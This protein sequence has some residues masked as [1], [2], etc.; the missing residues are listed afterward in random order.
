MKLK[1]Y[2]LL[3]IAGHALIF[4]SC[5]KENSDVFMPDNRHGMDT[6]WVSFI[7]PAM[8]VSML[9]GDL[10]IP[11]YK[12]SIDIAGNTAAELITSS[13]LKFL[14]PANCLTDYSHAPIKGKVD[15]QS[16]LIQ[17]KG[18]MIRLNKPSKVNDYVIASEGMLLISLKKN[19]DNIQLAPQTKLNI[20]Y[21]QSQPNDLVKLLQG[22]EIGQGWLNWHSNTEPA[23]NITAFNEGYEINTSKLGWIDAGYVIDS[24]TSQNISI[25]IELAKHFTNAN[26]TAWL[27]FKNYNAAVNLKA[28]AAARKFGVAEIPYNKDATLVVISKQVDDYYLGTKDIITSVSG[29]NTL[30]V[31]VKPVKISLDDLLQ[32]L[33]SL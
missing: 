32:Y 15:V 33:N 11:V 5:Q 30:S 13:G 2:I 20:R 28:D 29:G 14:L 17:K 12:D 3:I 19:G 27:V 10:S 18:D 25:S 8:P 31:P 4:S 26:T 22:E 23:N 24:N 16:L 9:A 7:D 6:S 1:K 21:N